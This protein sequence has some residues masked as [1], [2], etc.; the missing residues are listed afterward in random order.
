[1]EKANNKI[2]K[3]KSKINFSEVKQVLSDPEVISYLNVS[4]EQYVTY[5]IDKGGNNIAFIYKKY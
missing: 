2:K 1:M 3:L 5:P 4:Q